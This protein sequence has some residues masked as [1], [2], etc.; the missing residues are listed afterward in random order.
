ILFYFLAIPRII[1]IEQHRPAIEKGMEERIRLPVT[2]SEMDTSFTP[3]LGI[4]VYFDGIDIKHSDGRDFISTGPVYV[5][6]SIPSLLRNKV[7]IREIK[8]IKPI[9]HIARLR[10]G[11]FDI[12][13]LIPKKRVEPDDYEVIFRNTNI[14]VDEYRLYF[15]DQLI[16][17]EQNYELIGQRIRITDLDPDAFI[18][19][20]AQG[21]VIAP[22]RANTI[23][24]LNF[25]AE[26]PIDFERIWE[27][28]LALEGEIKNIYPDMYLPYIN[29]YTPYE[30]SNVSGSGDINLDINM[31]KSRLISNTFFVESTFTDFIARNGVTFNFPDNTRIIARGDIDKDRLRLREAN[32][33]R[34]DINARLRGNIRNYRARDRILDLRLN[35]DKTRIAPI[36]ALFPQELNLPTRPLAILQRYN[37]RGNM[38][39]DVAIRGKAKDLDLFGN[40]RFDDF[41]MVLNGERVPGGSGRIDFRGKTYVLDTR[42]F[43]DPTGYMNVN[44][45]IA[46]I[47]ERLNLNITSNVIDLAKSKRL[48]QA[49]SNI[50]NFPLGPVPQIGMS[51]KGRVDINVS[52][53]FDNVSLRGY[54][55]LINA[56]V[57]HPG[58]SKPAH[59]VVGFLRFRGNR[60]I[61]DNIRGFIEQSRATANGF[62]TLE[63]FSNVKL[64]FSRL[65]LTTAHQLIRNSTLLVEVH[66]ILK[67]VRNMSGIADVVIYLTGGP[68]GVAAS[69]NIMFQ[70]ASLSYV[71]LSDPI[72]ELFGQLRFDPQGVFLD[73]L[74][75]RIAQSPIVAEGSIIENRVDATL[76]STR[77]DIEAI[78]QF[79]INSPILTEARNALQDFTALSGIA[80]ARLRLVGRTDEDIFE[81][82]QLRIIRATFEHRQ[83][84]FPVSLFTGRILIT[85]EGIFFRDVSGEVLGAPLRL[86][87]Q[88]TGLATQLRPQLQLTVQNLQFARIK[89]LAQSPLVSEDIKQLLA[90]FTNLSGQIGVN[91]R[92]LPQTYRVNINLDEAFAFYQPA[93]LP[94]EF[95]DGNLI[96]TPERIIFDNVYAVIS[97]TFVYLDGLVSNYQT[98]PI[99]NLLASAR[100]NSEDIDE[101]INPYLEEPIIAEGIIPIAALAK[102]QLND[103]QVL[104]QATLPKGT[105]LMYREDIGL[106]EDRIRVLSLKAEGTQNRINVEN[107]EVA[108]GTNIIE[109][110]LSA[111]PLPNVATSL[112]RLLAA[113]GAIED[114][115]TEPVFDNFIVTTPNPVDV[116]LINPVIQPEA[117]RP[118]LTSGEFQ[119]RALLEGQVSDPQI[120]GSA[121]LNDIL[122]ASR[123]TLIDYANIEFNTENILVTNSSI[124]MAG[125]PIQVRAIA[126]NDFTRPIVIQEIA[127]SSP[128]FNVD[129]IVE[130]LRQPEEARREDK[131]PPVVVNRG[132]LVANE[133]IIGDLVT[134]NFSSC[135]S[136]EP[137][138]ILNMPNIVFESAGGNA[139]AEILYNLETTL[140]RANLQVQGMQANA[141]ATTLLS[142]PNEVY[143]TLEGTAEF[144]TQGTTRAELLENADGFADFL[145]T[146]GRLVRL[147]SLEYLLRAANILQSGITGLTLNNIID[148]IA[149]QETGHFEE[150]GG[151]LTALDGI[152]TTD[153][154]ESRGDPLSLF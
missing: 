124:N 12:E 114:L 30:Y 39:T 76:T 82:L 145:I 79:I 102:G 107:L 111:S 11:T 52:G 55:N 112:E 66:R 3:T 140:L 75:A 7:V 142:T 141:V 31:T 17:P 87:G 129:E 130:A 91:A 29:R 85:Q 88:I 108:T 51:G 49:I 43:L 34:E 128:S 92:I 57:S 125:S 60:V 35:V 97:K 41:S 96:I 83:I 59:D 121:L 136:F 36:V 14:I 62:S 56:V 44:G 48:L 135:F 84:G 10:D 81:D 8:I 65:N 126:E 147:G 73:R 153:N 54:L 122:I 6:I 86:A 70:G 90:E 18:R 113:E 58:F 45:T 150:F 101:Y 80:D 120:T 74:R 13:Q 123:E 148:V 98:E 89:Q 152:L 93:E 95:N 151:T 15:K 26:L 154:L 33:R 46:P 118:L 134:T 21:E 94:L 23:F 117:R 119:V 104:A 61:Y 133:L 5:E 38:W 110:G 143:G 24:D 47:L 99:L 144:M 9:A 69:G 131:V 2:I 68:K 50:F 146:D 105:V 37:V 4:R 42:F 28:K 16:Q 32:I 63:G 77:L 64:T 1:D 27:K 78:R 19:V 109:V 138:W 40:L 127:I 116:T 20:A 103:W 53:R 100:V 106:P 67:N 115:Q 71:G 132:I 25:A 72:R 22:Q 137:D 149:P 139:E